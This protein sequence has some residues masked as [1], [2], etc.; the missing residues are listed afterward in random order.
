MG[1]DCSFLS[2]VWGGRD[3][4]AMLNVLAEGGM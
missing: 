4:N 3:G 2:C 1:S